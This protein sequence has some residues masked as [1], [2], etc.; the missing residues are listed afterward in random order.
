MCIRVAG[1]EADRG[2]Q[3]RFCFTG[4]ASF[5][6]FCCEA[7][8]H[9]IRRLL[10]EQQLSEVYVLRGNGKAAIDSKGCELNG[11]ALMCDGFGEPAC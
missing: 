5:L 2:S 11:L 10:T 8:A 1:S 9:R 6:Y 4:R 3:R 7:S